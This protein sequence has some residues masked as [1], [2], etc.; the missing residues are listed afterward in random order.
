V[1]DWEWFKRF[2]RAII[3]AAGPQDCDAYDYFEPVC[4]AV[5]SILPEE[6]P[7]PKGEAKPIIFRNIK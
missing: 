4:K 1:N 7:A 6:R 3:E 5:E 2:V